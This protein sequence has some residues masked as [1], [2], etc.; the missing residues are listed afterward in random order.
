MAVAVAAVSFGAGAA[1]VL[2]PT[3]E[4]PEPKPFWHALWPK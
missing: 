1:V 3:E 4:P 2:E